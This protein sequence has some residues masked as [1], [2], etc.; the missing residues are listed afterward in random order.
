MRPLQRGK[1]DR[2]RQ[3]LVSAVP[4]GRGRRTVPGLCRRAIP[5][6]GPGRRVVR[7]VPCGVRPKRRR[8]GRVSAVHP[9]PGQQPRGPTGVRRVPAKHLCGRPR[10]HGL[11]GVRRGP[12]DPGQRQRVL[13]A[14]PRG[15]GWHTMH[16]V[17]RGE[18]P[19]RRHG[20]VKLRAV[21]R[22]LL[23]KRC[24]AGR[25][26]AVHSWPGQRS[27]GP[28]RLRSVFR[29]E[30]PGGERSHVHLLVMPCRVFPTRQQLGIV[31][32]LHP[33]QG[34]QPLGSGQVCA[35]RNEHLFAQ[36]RGPRLPE[37]RHRAIHTRVR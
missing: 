20:S 14:V 16:A 37:L 13:P 17:R 2:Q 33:G 23:P 25:V 7:A 24:R 11:P 28:G 32:A 6:R 36:P 29:G 22:G 34:Q 10:G 18:V 12:K 30:I 9:G 31:L 26:P 3:C 4:R 21:P 8:A 1:A 19:H 27:R 35:V 5:R 15:G